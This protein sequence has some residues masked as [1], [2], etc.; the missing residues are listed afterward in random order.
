MF[1]YSASLNKI[2]S[3]IE[4]IT[5]GKNMFNPDTR[6]IDSLMGNYSASYDTTDYIP[7]EAGKTYSINKCRKYGLYNTSKALIGSIVDNATNNPLSFT[8]SQDGYLKAAIFKGYVDTFQVE[9]S[10]ES[11]FHE[12]YKKIIT[13]TN[14][15]RVSNSGVE[16]IQTNLKLTKSGEMFN[17]T[18][19]LDDINDIEIKTIRNG[20]KNGSFTFGDVNLSSFKVHSPGDDITPIRTFSGATVGAGHGYPC[21]IRVTMA[22]HDKVTADLGSQWTD[23]V[24]VY[25]LLSIS[26][27]DLIFGCPYTVTADI[28]SSSVV[29]PVTNL[30]HVSGATHTT[31]VVVSTLVSNPQLYPSINNIT[32]KYILDGVDITED[33]TYY[34]NE[35]QVQESYNVMCYKEIIDY[36]QS[37]IG[38]SYAEADIPGVARLSINYVF[39]AKGSCVIHHNIRAL[40]KFNT[41]DCG[42]IQSQPMSLTGYKVWRYLPNVLPKS[43]VDFKTPVD[44]TTY[45]QSL[46]FNTTD[47]IDAQIP[48]NRSID[49]LINTSTGEKKIGF[50]MGYVI[51][52]SNS[53]HTERLANAADNLWDMRNTGKCYPNAL[54]GVLFNVGDYKNFICYRNYLSPRWDENA[55][56]FNIVKDKKDVYIYIDYHVNVSFANI[57]LDEFIGKT[58]T[59]LEKSTDFTLH[60][61]IIDADGVIFSVA[62]DYGYA[63]LKL[64]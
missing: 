24:T 32:V 52:K 19:M 59:V 30:T 50:T 31:T 46:V 64:E 1:G 10:P 6:S 57:K 27:D 38:A 5:P 34:G 63:V 9:E 23:G 49:W 55:T 22:G 21:I 14:N 25:T 8:A 53:K 45:S 3:L 15:V 4:T 44:L 7:V 39:G 48:P 47:L 29:N 12:P 62:N 56:N 11:T 20:S 61:T 58:I 2:N 40:K 43:G 26:E 33:G 18:S 37:N 42:F 60:N 17:I 41:I 54:R 51:D 35:L 36:A 28:V 16:G 13:L